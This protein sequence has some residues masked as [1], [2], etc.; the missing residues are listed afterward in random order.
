[1]INNPILLI[2][3]IMGCLDNINKNLNDIASVKMIEI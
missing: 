2:A 1:M 3:Q